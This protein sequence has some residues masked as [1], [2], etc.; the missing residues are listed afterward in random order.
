MIEGGKKVPMT[1]RRLRR[2]YRPPAS[3]RSRV[4][5]ITGIDGICHAMPR[6]LVIGLPAFDLQP[7]RRWHFALPGGSCSL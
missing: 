5:S 7:R 1:A 2:R 6:L 4:S 3:A